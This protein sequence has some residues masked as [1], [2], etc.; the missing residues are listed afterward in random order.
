MKNE[1]EKQKKKNI[2][3]QFDDKLYFII[4]NVY[5]EYMNY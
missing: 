5:V 1:N 4:Y 3:L 2:S